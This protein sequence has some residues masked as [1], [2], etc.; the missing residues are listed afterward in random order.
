MQTK[1][2]LKPLLAVA[3]LSAVLFSGSAYADQLDDIK[4]AGELVVGTEMQFAPFDYLEDGKQTGFNKELFAVVGEQLGVKIRF[5]DLPW[6]SVLPGL[7]AGKFDLVGGPLNVTKARKERYRFTLPVADATVGFLKK[8]KNK[9]FTQPSDVAGKAVGGSR[10][11]AQ[12]A[13]TREYIETLEGSTKVR[14]YVSDTQ[15]YADL[16]N[17]RIDAVGNSITNISYV[18]KQRPEVFEVVMPTFGEKIYFAYM[19]HKDPNSD[20]LIDAIN[21]VILEMHSDGRLEALQE[22]WFGMPMEVPTSDFEPNF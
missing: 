17:G 2:R 15:A 19:G 14:E 3:M 11:S 10:G 5:I 22:E 9:D 7:D 20:S 6:A 4:Q 12:L 13:Q 16:A 8:A 1:N 21:N 18:A